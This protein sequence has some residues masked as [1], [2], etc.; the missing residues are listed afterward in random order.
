MYRQTQMLSVLTSHNVTEKNPI[1]IRFPFC[2]SLRFASDSPG[3]IPKESRLK[4]ERSPEQ[5]KSRTLAVPESNRSI[6]FK[7]EKPL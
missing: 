7:L 5:T 2:V 1:N 6:R 3:R 4:L